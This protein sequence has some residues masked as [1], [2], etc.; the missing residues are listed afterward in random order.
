M[1]SL[2]L[3]E[4]LSI[5]HLSDVMPPN[6]SSLYGSL[7]CQYDMFIAAVDEPH[8]YSL[9]PATIIFGDDEDCRLYLTTSRER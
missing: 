3:I 9:T 4:Q 7:A 1:G 6:G 8:P 5:E 2:N